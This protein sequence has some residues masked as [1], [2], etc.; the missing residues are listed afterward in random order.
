MISKTDS[1]A[2]MCFTVLIL[3]LLL[4]VILVP[5]VL[6]AKDTPTFNEVEVCDKSSSLIIATDAGNVDISSLYISMIK[7]ISNDTSSGDSVVDILSETCGYNSIVSMDGFGIVLGQENSSDEIDAL[8]YEGETDSELSLD[9]TLFESCNFD[10]VVVEVINN[11]H[12]TKRNGTPWVELKGTPW[13]EVNGTPWVELRGEIGTVR[14]VGLSEAD[15]ES[16][17]SINI[18]AFPF[19]TLK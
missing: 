4:A 17:S 15:G 3:C 12:C 10:A 8:N 13:V 18:N 19:K 7:E 5:T 11:D 2:Q 6:Q 1:I 16:D 14:I 9:D